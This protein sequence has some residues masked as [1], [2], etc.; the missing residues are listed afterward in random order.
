MRVLQAAGP[1]GLAGIA[2]RRGRFVRP[3]AAASRADVDAHLAAAGLSARVDPSNA[4]PRF[5]RNRVRSLLLPVLD[6]AVPGWG[7]AVEGLARGMSRV[8]SFLDAEAAR[9]PWER[10]G[11][12]WVIDRRR[13]Y[14]AHPA[15]RAHALLL[16]ADRLPRGSR[17]ARIP[18][19]FL[20]PALGD[21]PGPSPRYLVRGHGLALRIEHDDLLWGPDI[22]SAVEKGYLVVVPD[23]GSFIIEGTG[24]TVSFRRGTDP[25]PGETAIPAAEVVPPVVLRSR[26]K[27][28]RIEVPGGGAAPPSA[29]GARGHSR[30][31]AGHVPVLVDRRGVVAVLGAAVGGRTATRTGEPAPRAACLL[32]RVTGG[33]KE[34]RA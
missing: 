4:D 26:R 5:L 12:G 11:T 9:L 8:A 28:D 2:P 24:A 17:P 18:R 20:E 14:A 30:Q 33:A 34:R 3:L 27:G 6:R 1:R 29:C 13:F 25:Q 16:L 21:D 31:P 7:T 19:R 22:V 10:R 15:L 23:G 32:V